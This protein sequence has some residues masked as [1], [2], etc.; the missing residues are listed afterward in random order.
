MDAE[1]WK[2]R[3][4]KVADALEVN[5]MA[6]VV[7]R[8][9]KHGA[10]QFVQDSNFMYLTGLEVPEAVL[11]LYKSARKTTELLFI[12][13]TIPERI[14]WEG[15]KLSPTDAKRLAGFEQVYFL[16]ELYPVFSAYL[17]AATKLYANT[18][19][20]VLN[21]PTS[22]AA[23]LLKP[24][25]EA[26]PTL[27]I[28]DINNLL[29]PIR[30]VKD[31]W[32][33]Q[34]LQTAID[35]TAEGIG[36][37]L[38]KARAGMWE[39]ELE[40]K[41][42]HQFHKKGIRTWGFA[43]IVGTGINAATLHYEKNNCQLQDGEVVLMDVGAS[44]NGYS[45]DITRCFPVNAAFSPRQKEVY[46]QVLHIQKEIISLIKP[47]VGLMELNTKTV[48][49]MGIALKELKLITEASEVS[50]YYMHSI[51]HHLGL[52]THDIGARDSILTA[53]NIITIEPGIYIP[54][55]Q[56]GIRIEDDVLVTESGCA[57]L[58]KNIP[59]EVAEIEAIRREALS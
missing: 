32:E 41:I 50:R 23:F 56:L 9:E 4:M 13:R 49:L 12:Q 59:K 54:E 37:V 24:V 55:E 52:D 11:C 57:V 40:A 34:Q 30:A 31:T 2:A 58:S 19:V 48:E 28:E 1:Y 42:Y 6:V 43:P 21:R 47:G 15:E 5:Q 10:E 26:Y 35:L 17:P 3:R 46:G 25:R 29:R 33:I 18:G 14:V 53:G 51:G 22:F 20:P 7:A 44:Y 39:Y 8:P 36:K 38:H 45:A 27:A 16:D